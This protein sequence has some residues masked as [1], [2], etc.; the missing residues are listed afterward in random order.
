MRTKRRS[1]PLALFLELMKCLFLCAVS[2]FNII[3]YIFMIVAMIQNGDMVNIVYPLSIFA[4]AIYE[5]CRPSKK[6]WSLIIF[7]TLIIIIVK[8]VF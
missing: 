7:Y 6:F 1:K 8:F 5:E 3:I 2:N 4:Y